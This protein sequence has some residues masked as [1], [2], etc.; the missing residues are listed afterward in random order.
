VRQK[1]IHSEACRRKRDGLVGVV[2]D[3]RLKAAK[4]KVFLS[5]L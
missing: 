1:K 5:V 3:G 2:L 4:R